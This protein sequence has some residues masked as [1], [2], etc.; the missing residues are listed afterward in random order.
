[1]SQ[2]KASYLVLTIA[3]NINNIKKIARCILKACWM[4]NAG[5]LTRHTQKKTRQGDRSV[6]LFDRRH[7]LTVYRAIGHA[8]VPTESANSWD[9]GE[10]LGSSKSKTW[11][12]TPNAARLHQSM[13]WTCECRCSLQSLTAPWPL[14]LSL[15]GLPCPHISCSHTVW[16]RPW[17]CPSS[18]HG[19]CS[20]KFVHSAIVSPK[21][22]S[23]CIATQCLG[24]TSN[25]EII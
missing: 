11:N 20:P 25:L 24:I 9:W 17:W 4:M 22:C 6:K 18:P 7:H 2:R 15:L 21:H 13:W 8:P 19:Q 3:N 12:S 10:S 5:D 23:L 1:M 16:S 14:C